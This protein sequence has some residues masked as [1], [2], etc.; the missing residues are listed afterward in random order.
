MDLKQ[1]LL[2]KLKKESLLINVDTTLSSGTASGYYIDG[3]MTTLDPEGAYLTAGVLLEVLEPLDCDA[4]GGLTIGANPIVTALALYSYLKSSP[5]KAFIV[6][7]EAKKHGTQKMIEGKLGKKVV[8]VDDVV[9]TGKS[10]K[11]ALKAVEAEGSEV[12]KIIALV[13][14]KPEDTG[15]FNGYD[16]EAIFTRQ[17][18]GI[19]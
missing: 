10:I 1:K 8:I 5:I 19:S 17:D 4:V 13:D 6:R 12:V 3:K 11:D 15:R 14:R 9:T 2:D 16:F 7:K 18:L